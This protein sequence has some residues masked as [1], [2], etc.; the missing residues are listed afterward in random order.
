[1]PRSTPSRHRWPGARSWVPAPLWP[2]GIVVSEAVTNVVLHAY[3]DGESGRV[4]VQASLQDTLL[5]LVVADDGVGMMA[6]PDSP[7]LAAGLG[8]HPQSR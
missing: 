5:T 3:R 6:N 1:M 8:A 2:V 4:R 7:G